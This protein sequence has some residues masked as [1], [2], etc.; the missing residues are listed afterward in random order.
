MVTD[1][2]RNGKPNYFGKYLEHAQSMSPN[3]VLESGGSLASFE[4]SR[5]R[6]ILQHSHRFEF[7]FI[8]P[9]RLKSDD[10]TTQ[11]PSYRMFKASRSHDVDASLGRS[12]LSLKAAYRCSPVS[13]SATQPNTPSRSTEL[14][15]LRV[16]SR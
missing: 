1:R 5:S 10:Y 12:I 4:V 16:S 6:N 8:E 15:L 14:K 7:A 13:C 3:Y 9:K 2:P 11:Y